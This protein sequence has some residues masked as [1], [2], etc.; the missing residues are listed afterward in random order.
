MTLTDLLAWL[1]ALIL[2]VF[3]FWLYL[4]MDKAVNG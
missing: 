2:V 3:I 1:M 4:Q